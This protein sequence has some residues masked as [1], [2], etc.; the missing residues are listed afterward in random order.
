M[1][2]IVGLVVPKKYR[3]KPVQMFDAVNSFNDDVNRMRNAA[4]GRGMAPV[5]KGKLL[6]RV[7]LFVAEWRVWFRDS[8]SVLT[9]LQP[10]LDR[11]EKLRPSVERAT[12]VKLKPAPKSLAPFDMIARTAKTVFVLAAVAAGLAVLASLR[13]N[14]GE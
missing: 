11:Y 14:R 1:T 3:G 9:S 7:E 6:K 8:T 13:K 10:W 4:L 2:R 5:V 12:G